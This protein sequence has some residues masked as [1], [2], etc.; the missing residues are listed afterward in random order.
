MNQPKLTS[1]EIICLRSWFRQAISTIEVKEATSLFINNRKI[2]EGQN[3][4]HRAPVARRRAK[5][6]F[7]TGHSKE[8]AV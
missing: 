5:R 8:F 4:I 7:V 2:L 1:D 6:A 3:D